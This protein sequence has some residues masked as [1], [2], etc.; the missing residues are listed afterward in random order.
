M[1]RFEGRV[2]PSFADEIA[3]KGLQ[4]RTES[5]T[6]RRPKGSPHRTQR[7][8]WDSQ[9]P[10]LKGTSLRETEDVHDRSASQ[11]CASVQDLTAAS[12]YQGYMP[13]SHSSEL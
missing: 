9:H 10:V 7:T 8:M 4:S 13:L 3:I 1:R 11:V 5:M 6:L 2:L 12:V